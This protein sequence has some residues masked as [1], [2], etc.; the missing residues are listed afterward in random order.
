M[1]MSWTQ[2]SGLPRRLADAV[3][4]LLAGTGLSPNAL[5]IASF[6]LSVPVAWVL[7]EGH[8]V[9]GGALLLL[10]SA[11]DAVD[12]SLARATGKASAF[13][14]LLDSTLDRLSEA[15]LLFGLLLFYLRLGNKVEPLLVYA[16]FVSSVLVSY[17]RAR[18]EG[19]GYD[20]KVG[21]LTRPVR[22]LILGV[23]LMVSQALVALWILA[24]LTLFTAGQRV[25]HRRRVMR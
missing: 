12:G 15:V 11:W 20:C 2:L 9:L 5:T 7:A 24:V 23:G 14:A 1:V 22:V 10:V 18:A 17:V 8:F 4:L 25:A 13:G 16:T 19:L 3:A 21:L 6:L